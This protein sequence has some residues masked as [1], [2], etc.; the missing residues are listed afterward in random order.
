MYNE[1]ERFRI[2]PV[3]ATLVP[4]IRSACPPRHSNCPQYRPL[5]TISM[6]AMALM[7]VCAPTY[8]SYG[9]GTLND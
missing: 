5:F 4:V 7:P 9:P 1:L 2:D 8:W 3:A 6:T